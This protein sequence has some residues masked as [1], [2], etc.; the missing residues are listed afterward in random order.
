MLESIQYVRVMMIGFSRG[1]ETVWAIIQRF[2]AT[3]RSYLDTR[4]VY[5]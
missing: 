3:I 1:N 5:N 4:A 2:M